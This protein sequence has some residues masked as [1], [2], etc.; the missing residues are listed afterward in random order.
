MGKVAISVVG[1]R[2]VGRNGILRKP[3]SPILPRFIVGVVF[4][5]DLNVL[6]A[7]AAD[8]IQV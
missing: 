1:R 8:H 6:F 7:A 5:V 4:Q 3:P 2:F